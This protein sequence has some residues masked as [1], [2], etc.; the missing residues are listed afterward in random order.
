MRFSWQWPGIPEPCE[1]T[2]AARHAHPGFHHDLPL[3]AEKDV[4]S[5]AEFDQPHPIAGGYMIPGL[6]AEHN[7]A[8]DQARDLLEDNAGAIPAHSHD[9]LLILV[10]ANLA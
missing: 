4:D 7:T 5:G 1:D 6:W 10:G 8:C 3:G 9:V 2:G